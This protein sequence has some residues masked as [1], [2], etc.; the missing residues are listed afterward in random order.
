MG[1]PP[2]G[3]DARYP[4]RGVARQNIVSRPRELLST[5]VTPCFD[6]LTSGARFFEGK[7]AIRLEAFATTELF[8]S[9]D[10][11][12]PRSAVILVMAGKGEN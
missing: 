8:L 12:D 6:S 5:L 9:D 1:P 4:C 7:E 10:P 11:L 2:T 3:E